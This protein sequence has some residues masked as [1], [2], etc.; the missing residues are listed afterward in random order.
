MIRKL[1]LLFNTVKHLRLTQMF[2]QLY[3]RLKA[4]LPLSSYTESKQVEFKQIN[5][6]Y[7]L[8]SLP[9]A[10][11][12]NSFTFLNLTRHFENEIDWNYQAFGKL[13]NYNLQYFN[14]LQQSELSNDYKQA[15]LSS[16]EIWLKDGRLPLEPYPVS[17]R[18]MNMI[19]F[20]SIN[21]NSKV[22]LYGQLNYLAKHLEFHLL[23]NHLLEN[24]FALA[25][26]GQVFNQ[27]KWKE[28]AKQILYS[29]LDE[30]ILVDGAH[31]ELSP[32][33]H[34]IILFRVL[35]LIEWYTPIAD[36][37]TFLDFLINKA[38]IML[39]WL[40]KMTFSNGDIPNFNDSAKD[41]SY[42]TDNLIAYYSFLGLPELSVCKLSESG[43][44]KFDFATYECTIDVGAI[45]PNYQ[46]GHAHADALSFILYCNGKPLF[47]E[48]GTSTYQISA[49]RAME[50][51]T[52]AHNCVVIDGKDQSQVWGGFRVGKRASVNILKDDEF[53]VIAEH[54]GYQDLGIIHRREFVCSEN[55]IEIIDLLKGKPNQIGL[56][57]FHLESKVP[58][59]IDGNKIEMLG[60]ANLYFEGLKSLVVEDYELA[61]GFNKYKNAKRIIATFEGRLKTT[62]KL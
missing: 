20:G 35:E 42:S 9:C 54:N 8:P 27:R 26:G 49:K 5:F 40:K 19:R 11:A 33:Y 41:I 14:W 1:L 43:Y 16:I 48:Q 25:M 36:D 51:A 3:Y 56:A 61:D 17:L 34:Q 12:N 59:K 37:T 55:C 15:T 50:R 52:Q 46:P 24:A 57:Y 31:F 53:H 6:Q 23:G 21:E 22:A 58:V 38:K 2:H 47:V 62:I 32:M 4:K 45:G 7:I 39:T 29:E 13:W 60:Y 10:T 28:M 18:V 44:R 30:Q